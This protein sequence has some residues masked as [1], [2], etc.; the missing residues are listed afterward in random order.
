MWFSETSDR[1]H[2][3]REVRHTEIRPENTRN[4]PQIRPK[5]SLVCRYQKLPL[6]HNLGLTSP[7]S[8]SNVTFWINRL[9]RVLTSGRK[10][11]NTLYKYRNT[12]KYSSGC[13]SHRISKVRNFWTGCRIWLPKKAKT[14]RIEFP[15]WWEHCLIDQGNARGG[16]GWLMM[17]KYG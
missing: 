17:M 11:R 6:N 9:S 5:Y 12:H 15:D 8:L 2:S 16:G 10:Y 1:A 14:I 7:N 13:T 4:P 3:T